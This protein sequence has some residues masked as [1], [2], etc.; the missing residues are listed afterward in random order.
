MP[1]MPPTP[2]A[3]VPER[4]ELLEGPGGGVE[5]LR[6]PNQLETRSP[7][8]SFDRWNHNFAD[9]LSPLMRGSLNW[10]WREERS[11]GTNGYH[12]ARA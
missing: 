9:V 2:L 10:G 5:D 6:Q 11:I 3:V 7:G 8:S 12:G 1:L 4:F